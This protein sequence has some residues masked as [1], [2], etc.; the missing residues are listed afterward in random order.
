MLFNSFEFLVFF[1]VVALLF[2]ILPGRLRWPMVLFASY[3]FYMAW[4]PAYIVLIL[5]STCIDYWAGLRMRN[6]SEQSRRRPYLYVSLAANLGLLFSFKYFNFANEALRNAFEW[7]HTPYNVPSL[8]VL[9]PVGISFYTFQTLAYTIDIYRGRMEPETRFDRFALYVAFFPQLVAG[10]IERSQNLLPQLKG[11]PAFEY[12]RVRS[13]CRLILWGLFKKVVIADQ[14]AVLADLVYSQPDSFPSACLIVA[15]V[16]FA[17]QIY[18]DFSGYTDI[19]IGCARI[20]GVELMKNFNRPYAALSLADFWRRWHISLTTWFRDYL[21]IPL[22]GNQLGTRRRYANV[23]IVFALSGLWHGA[24]WTF[25]VWGMLH[26]IFYC[27]GTATAAFRERVASKLMLTRAPRLHKGL[28]RAVTFTLV[29]VA[30]IFF[31]ANSFNDA[32]GI[33]VNLTFGA[34]T[35]FQSDIVELTLSGMQ[36][37]PAHALS[38]CGGVAFLLAFEHFQGEGDANTAFNRLPLPLRWFL[39]FALALAC[40]NL[41]VTHEIPFIYFQF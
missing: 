10:P 7:F 24:N 13:G 12:D 14:L 40:M 38:L 20:F 23:V 2:F 28:K 22:G 8:D 11:R 4:E 35:L 29:C 5:L 33:L 17:F 41:G 15:T 18:C 1:P 21:Y 27:A 16:S 39:Y 31:R 9:L 19:A 37:T 26:A 6:I 30:W 34:S 25:L 3:I 32:I 36:L